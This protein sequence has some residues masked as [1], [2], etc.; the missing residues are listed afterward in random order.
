ME[1]YNAINSFPRP[2]LPDGFRTLLFS[3][4]REVLREQPDN[5]YE[6]CAEFFGKRLLNR[7]DS[8]ISFKE[9][10]NTRKKER[11][12]EESKQKTTP[13]PVTESTTDLS[14]QFTPEQEG[15]AV[16][17]QAGVRG[18]LARRSMTHTEDS[19]RAERDRWL[20]PQEQLQRDLLTASRSISFAQLVAE[21]GEWEAC[22][23]WLHPAE[24]LQRD[25]ETVAEPVQFAHLRDRGP[26]L[27]DTTAVDPL[28]RSGSPAEAV[29]PQHSDI[30]VAG[31][32]AGLP[33]AGRAGSLAEVGSP[34][35]SAVS[36]AGVTSPPPPARAA[37]IASVQS[38]QH[39][40]VSLA[41]REP[42]AADGPGERAASLEAVD[43]EQAPPP[44]EDDQTEPPEPPT[45]VLSQPTISSQLDLAGLS[46]PSAGSA[47]R[48]GSP[49]EATTPRHS[50]LQLAEGRQSPPAAVLRAGS[51]PEATTPRHSDVD[52]AE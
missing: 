32:A 21:D 2:N 39:S 45:D 44:P 29:T 9:R 5:L 27:E 50:D 25:Y 46:P 4:S 47:G 35:Y 18:M 14:E 3:L 30:D 41:D 22:Q 36:V 31:E 17:I 1:D 13:D 23:R 34:V 10:Y 16:K 15:A 49:P 7:G 40:D 42:P 51:P 8:W 24:Q 12:K 28:E 6:F 37:S 52:L 26:S 43:S 48:A 11:A 33:E 20:Q 38:A 19:A